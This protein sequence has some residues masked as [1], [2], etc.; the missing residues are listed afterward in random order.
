MLA[1]GLYVLLEGWR[2]KIQ[3][4]NQKLLKQSVFKKANM[5]VSKVYLDHNASSSLLNAARETMHKVMDLTGN[6]SSVHANGRVLANVIETARSHV[7]DLAGADRAQ[8]VFTGS[9]TESITQA[10][11]GSIKA[12]KLNRVLI[13]AGEHKAL[14]SAAELSGAEVEV[15]G[16]DGNGVIDLEALKVAL[17]RADEAGKIVLVAVH[18][19]NNETGVV[20]DISQIGALVGPSKHFLFVDGVQAFGKMPLDFAKSGMD[21]LA[22]AAHKIGGPAGVGALV[23]KD[24]CSEVRIIPGGGHEQGRRGGT[25]SA[26]LIAGFGAAAGAVGRIWDTDKIDAL[27]SKFEAGISVLG[28]DVVIFGE[29]ATRMGNV[30]N[31][32]VPGISSEAMLMALDLK[33]ICV[34]AGSACSS[35]KITP[36]TVLDGMGIEPDI[37]KCALRVSVGWDS[38]MEDIELALVALAQIYVRH[39]KQ[40]ELKSFESM[41]S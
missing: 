38:T 9:A 32:A 14:V 5:P 19:V 2:W 35:G 21:M 26:M 8:V 36:S 13:S 28:P 31:F 20:Q 30:C 7:A 10:I 1:L 11:V 12:F 24:H 17:D 16:L 18:W 37:A 25:Q 4:L 3:G 34:S 6:P 23:M 40:S 15:I 33:G 29:K 41:G 22:V 27:M 39:S